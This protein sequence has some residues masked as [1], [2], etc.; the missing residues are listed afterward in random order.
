MHPVVIEWPGG[1]HQF[2]LR[3]GELSQ[4]QE[5][6]DCGPEFLLRKLQAGQ[7]L[8][9]ELREI[10]RLG[11]I[12]GGMD[13]VSALKAVTRALDAAPLMT[14]K[15]P[16]LTVLIAA[17]YGPPDDEAGKTLPEVPTPAPE[18]TENGSSATSTASAQRQAS[19]RKRSAK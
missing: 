5:K 16:A 9:V 1:E 3:L 10:L 8:A 17:L 19:A 12:G 4:L 7:W 2:Q 14:F 6:T 13:H 11:L 18:K 15:V